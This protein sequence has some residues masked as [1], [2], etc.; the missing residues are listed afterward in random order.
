MYTL[1]LM[2]YDTCFWFNFMYELN[3][4]TEK[5]EIQKKVKFD[6]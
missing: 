6:T 5:V 2:L 1:S 4:P 3:E